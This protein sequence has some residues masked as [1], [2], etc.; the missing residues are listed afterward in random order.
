MSASE[1]SNLLLQSIHV[2]YLLV[3][4]ITKAAP[5]CRMLVAGWNLLLKNDTVM[6][7]H[8]NGKLFCHTKI[9]FFTCKTDTSIQLHVVFSQEIQ[10]LI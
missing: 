10:K 7:S 9:S 3:I 6:K 4:V 8:N 5:A 2:T 1:K